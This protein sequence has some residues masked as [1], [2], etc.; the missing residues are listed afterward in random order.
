Q[1]TVEQRESAVSIAVSDNGQGLSPQFLPYVFDRFRQADPGST[2]L[3]GGL[4]LGLSI[5]KHLVE[6]HGGT[7]KAESEGLGRGA[8]FTV[9]LPTALS[10]KS[11]D[12]A[13]AP[14][15]ECPPEVVGLRILII[16][17]EKD[18]RELLR[19][20]LVGF[21]VLVE[22]VASVPE[23]TRAF[24]AARP[25]LVISDIGMPHADG[26]S[27]IR[28]VRALPEEEGGRVPSIALTA[29]AR[30][31]DRTAALRAGFRAHIPKPLDL[32]ELLAVIV[33]LLPEARAQR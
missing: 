29:F 16:E 12:A 7:V 22:A 31:E 21:G 18:T 23:A 9:L 20:I 10:Q 6:L 15:I 4:G 8:R 33:S 24:R 25:D 1:I 11:P 30:S 27:F 17:D 14:S 26:F 28:W 2:R 13:P 19:E 32:S 5:V 3:H